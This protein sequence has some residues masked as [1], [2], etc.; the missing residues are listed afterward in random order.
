MTRSVLT[1]LTLSGLILAACGGEKA[2]TT[3]PDPDA[4]QGVTHQVSENDLA[5][6]SS[7]QPIAGNAAV[8]YVNGLG[9]P[10]CATNIDKQ[11]LRSRGI[12]SA[13]V[14]LGAGTVLVA[15]RDGATR[16]SPYQLKEIVADAG[17]TLM[18][19]EPR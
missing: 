13:A 18:K 8:L 6:L 1:A 7:K 17:F 16:P 11:L 14:D 10:L 19:V 4:P 15:F 2:L 9:C 12:G 5:S 3:T